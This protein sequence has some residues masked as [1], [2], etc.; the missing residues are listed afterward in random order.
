MTI[1]NKLPTKDGLFAWGWTVDDRC[2]H[3]IDKL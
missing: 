2:V 3:F 1:L